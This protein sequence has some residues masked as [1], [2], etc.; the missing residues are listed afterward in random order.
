MKRAYFRNTSLFKTTSIILLISILTNTICNSQQI[1]KP[2]KN[3]QF[4]DSVLDFYKLYSSFTDPGEYAYLYNNLP[5]SLPELCRLI[6]SQY[7]NYGWELDD[8]RELI[9]EGRWNESVKY[10]TVRSALKGLLSYDSSGLVKNRKPENRLILTCRDNAILLASILKYRGIPT[11]VRYGFATYLIPGFHPYH[12]ICEVWNKNDNRWMLIDPS[13]DKIDFSREEFEFSN[14]VWLKMHNNKIDPELYGIPGEF[15]GLMP[16]ILVL[17]SDQASILGNEYTIGQYPPILDYAI[18]NKQIPSKHI[19]TLSKIGELMKAI[20]A[21]S[22]SELK[23]IFDTNPQIQFTKSFEPEAK[24]IEN[25][26][27]TNN[28]STN[29]PHI[30]FVEPILIHYN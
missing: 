12:V 10:M 8:Y 4:D 29:K 25:N 15:T 27:L 14:D 19:E 17:C 30:E 22:I 21:E 11:R 13:A 28:S 5:D 6:R 7:I 2:T 9:P 23:E 3:I 1:V 20:D 26:T 16:I 24:I 18:E